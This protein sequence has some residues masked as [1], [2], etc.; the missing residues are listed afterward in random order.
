M[1]ELKRVFG[2]GGSVDGMKGKWKTNGSTWENKF[3]RS[4][5]RS[6]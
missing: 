1:T 5:S 4:G 2:G 6:G 3:S